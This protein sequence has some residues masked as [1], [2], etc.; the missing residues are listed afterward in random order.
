MLSVLQLHH[1]FDHKTPDTTAPV[2]PAT[3]RGTGEG[4]GPEEDREIVRAS[5]DSKVAPFGAL[6]RFVEP[7][8]FRATVVPKCIELE[9]TPEESHIKPEADFEMES[10]E[11]V[12]RA[13][14]AGLTEPIDVFIPVD[15]GDEQDMMVFLDYT[16]PGI[17]NFVRGVRVVWVVS[18]TDVF[19][20]TKYKSRPAQDAADPR[21]LSVKEDTEGKD[22]KSGVKKGEQA[23][24]RGDAEK[25]EGNHDH[26]DAKDAV[27]EATVEEVET[28]EQERDGGGETREENNDEGAEEK[29]SNGKEEASEE[30]RSG[31]QETSE[32]G[33]NEKEE[34]S[35]EGGNDKE[36][37]SEEGGSGEK[38]SQTEESSENGDSQKEG[39]NEE[40]KEQEGSDEASSE[41]EPEEDE[42]VFLSDKERRA[43]TVI[44]GIPFVWV[45]E[46]EWKY[47]KEDFGEGTQPPHV[48]ACFCALRLTLSW[49]MCRFSTIGVSLRRHLIYIF[50]QLTLLRVRPN[51]IGIVNLPSVMHV[52]SGWL[53]QQYL[54][55]YLFEGI[56]DALDTVLIGT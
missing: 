46:T 26:D 51:L 44:N 5:A 16:V 53:Y 24:K 41:E 20:G 42:T 49:P 8:P 37:T 10:F 7:S 55:M 39:R 34:T 23:R 27:T 21:S 22:E 1:Q 29:E 48:S 19:A 54:K 18:Q 47:S 14:E 6:P 12:Q 15:A 17:I 32:E 9:R 33:G 3:L 36:E 40:G 11:S 50:E 35:E 38:E 13:A 25:G 30:D 56:A 43:V 31:N 2:V 52:P 4:V 45:S 28:Q